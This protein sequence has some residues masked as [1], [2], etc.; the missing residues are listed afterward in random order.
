M[1]VR[2]SLRYILLYSRLRALTRCGLVDAVT[3]LTAAA[4][5]VCSC[6]RG[7]AAPGMK[8]VAARL[9]ARTRTSRSSAIVCPTPAGARSQL[10]PR[11]NGEIVKVISSRKKLEANKQRRQ[12]ARGPSKLCAVLF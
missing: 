5:R 4:G 12:A 10:A 9:E 3:M 8:A 11:S 6:S 7:G 1:R 2:I